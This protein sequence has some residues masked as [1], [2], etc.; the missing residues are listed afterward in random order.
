MSAFLTSKFKNRQLI[1]VNCLKPENWKN[2]IL[3]YLFLLKQL[4]HFRKAAVSEFRKLTQILPLIEY[5]A[6][7]AKIVNLID[8]IE[9]NL[10][11]IKF[12]TQI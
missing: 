6:E 5:A 2:F 3:F 9:S 1:K 11:E 12:S 4:K 10:K 8:K 7:M